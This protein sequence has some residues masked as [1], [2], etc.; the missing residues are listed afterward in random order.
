MIT[1]TC[2]NSI[3]FASA[4]TDLL[5][6][7]FY[8]A[9]LSGTYTPNGT[10]YNNR[11]S[12]WPL[13]ETKMFFYIPGLPIFTLSEKKFVCTQ[14]YEHRFYMDKILIFRPYYKHSAGL[15]CMWYNKQWMVADCR[16]PLNSE[17]G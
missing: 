15:L 2:C 5:A 12:I 4:N 16:N 14:L 3:V 1:V 11:C 9:Y 8:A 13:Q 10:I 7:P 6:T 17:S